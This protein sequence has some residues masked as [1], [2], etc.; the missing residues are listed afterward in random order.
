MKKILIC[1]LHLPPFVDSKEMEASSRPSKFTK[2]VSDFGRQ[3][4]V[5]TARLPV[6]RVIVEDPQTAN[7]QRT[8][9][10]DFVHMFNRFMPNRIREEHG[11]G[12][13]ASKS[14]IFLDEAVHE[15]L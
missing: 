3:P 6:E 8:S 11:R 9:F 12:E 7:V 13:L 14:S 15:D 10:L 4:L 2:Y 5:L 1:A